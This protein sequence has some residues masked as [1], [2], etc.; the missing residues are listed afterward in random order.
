MDSGQHNL[1]ERES[2]S[3]KKSPTKTLHDILSHQSERNSTI[4]SESK[5]NTIE[6]CEGEDDKEIEFICRQADLSPKAAKKIVKKGKRQLTVQLPKRVI[7]KRNV[8]N[9]KFNK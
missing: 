4:S 2:P 1:E 5:I 6:E 7:L 3:N 8:V 9:N